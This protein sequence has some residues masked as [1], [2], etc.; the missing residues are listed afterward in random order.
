MKKLIL[1]LAISFLA[2]TIKAQ[3]VSFDETV[4]YIQSR[5]S[6]IQEFTF[7]ITQSSGDI[8]YVTNIEI[9]QNGNITFIFAGENDHLKFNIF[10]IQKIENAISPRGESADLII[11]LEKTTDIAKF[12]YI[13]FTTNAEAKRL[14]KAFKNLWVVCIKEVDPFD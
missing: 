13:T 8:K 5:V 2:L 9:S 14:E 3:N 1:L 4:G 12:L 10:D 6:S 11:F 7:F